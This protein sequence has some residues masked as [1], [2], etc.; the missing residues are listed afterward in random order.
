L[1]PVPLAH[2][3]DEV[4]QEDRQHD[5]EVAVSGLSANVPTH[6]FRHHGHRQ[7]DRAQL[8]LPASRPVE[9]RAAA[10]QSEDEGDEQR[11][12][13]ASEPL[14]RHRQAVYREQVRKADRP[15]VAFEPSRER[16][17]EYVEG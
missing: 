13:V 14:Q 11:L 15:R 8:S 5:T 16:K 10:D 1:R 6:Q 7:R 12:D 9:Q 4:P 3:K 2:R 17:R